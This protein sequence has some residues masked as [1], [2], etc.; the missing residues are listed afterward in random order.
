MATASE[1]LSQLDSEPEET[2]ASDL[3]KK[4]SEDGQTEQKTGGA[5]LL[6]RLKN[7]ATETGND[8]KDFVSNPEKVGR[9][10]LQMAGTGVGSAVGSAIP[11][12]GT[13]AGGGLGY[14][15]ANQLADILYNKQDKSYS[16]QA[17]K[18]I[19]DIGEGALYELGG[20]AMNAAGSGI[21]RITEGL[22]ENKAK[23]T[24]S[25][26][27]NQ[28]AEK[29][30]A[31][32]L[33]RMASSTPEIAD[34]I[35]KNETLSS[36]IESQIPGLKFNIGQRGSDPN[37][38]S[39]ARKE[40]Q[41]AG[42]GAE[43]AA[44]SVMDQERAIKNYIDSHIAGNGNIDDFLKSIETFKERLANK[45]ST[46]ISNKEREALKLV[47]EP[48]EKVGSLLRDKATANLVESS[49]KASAL[50]EKVPEN[51][52]VESQPLWD[53]V[54]ELFGGFDALSQR[55]SATPTGSMGRIKEAMTP[56]KGLILDSKG[57]PYQTKTTPEQLTMKQMK[58][59]RTQMRV[60]QDAALKNGD[61]EL[62]YKTGQLKKAVNESLNLTA[63]TGNG[64][65]VEALKNAT[66]YYRDVHVPT[67]RQGAT[68]EILSVGNQIGGKRV[69][70]SSVGSMY[71]KGGSIGVPEAV[72][73]FNKTFGSDPEAK[74]LI[75]DYAAQSLL[76]K[77]RNPVTQEIDQ[78]AVYGWLND[79]KEA[80][81][82]YGI[83]NDFSDF[84][85][86]VSLAEKA[87]SLESE[88]NKSSAEKM[89]GVPAEQAIQSV[90]SNGAANAQSLSRLR[91]LVRIA[92][93]DDTGAAL[94][95]LKSGIGD[96]FKESI[97]NVSRDLSKGK[98]E[99]L[100]KAD[101][102]IKNYIPALRSSGA[103]STQELEAFNNVHSAIEIIASQQRPPSG[104]SGS[105][106]YELITQAL[107]SG[108]NAVGGKYSKAASFLSDKIINSRINNVISKAV[109]D[110]EYAD[111]I[112]RLALSS[113]FGKPDKALRQFN[114][115]I[116]SLG[117]I[118][119]SQD[120]TEE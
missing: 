40:S 83:I 84:K 94:K 71:F 96:Y 73:S 16:K 93:E 119:E 54:D 6:D 90:F 11:I 4:L 37:L 76:S 74:K 77:V 59:F 66:S 67:F 106:T 87:K 15:M 114:S 1:L 85:S 58:E 12:Y 23:K 18:A 102:F 28:Y 63:E 10:G 116:M 109:F 110:P 111:A 14:S 52:P 34:Q 2:S 81:T 30:A 107:K 50:Y 8:I 24:L 118:P 91:Q 70:D 29:R 101:R 108:A 65:G 32:K 19:S 98:I 3:L 31:E 13:L 117:F 55:L 33:A 39:L 48:S 49:K 69:M 47:G 43:R 45:T 120:N 75:K 112:T 104:F 44:I 60:A 72:E 99:S 64:E 79:H 78:K 115:K 68:N 42:Q 41:T 62:A 25:G 92:R 17:Q 100:A 35:I 82:R 46:A 53:K 97:S 38:L 89:L 103:Y 5:L 26:M 56:E 80:L 27:L 9:L 57:V 105:P 22:G 21:Y 61:Y 86:A 7:Y 95:G 51:M 20:K 36:E 113:R 88:F